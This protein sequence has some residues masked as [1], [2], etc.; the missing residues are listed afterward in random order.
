MRRFTPLI[1]PFFFAVFLC[2]NI[3][4]AEEGEVPA[5]EEPTSQKGYTPSISEIGTSAPICVFGGRLVEACGFGGLNARLAYLLRPVRWV[6]FGAFISGGMPILFDVGLKARA[7]L[8]TEHLYVDLGGIFMIPGSGAYINFMP[9]GGEVVLGAAAPVSRRISL[10]FEGQVD[11]MA[12][13]RGF[14][15]I[16]R[17]MFGVSAALG[18]YRYD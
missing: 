11:L 12:S 15:G 2:T 18:K 8:G 3:A 6:A 14:V 1:T 17:A 7:Y 4:T 5:P 10:V 9:Y 16:F 13:S